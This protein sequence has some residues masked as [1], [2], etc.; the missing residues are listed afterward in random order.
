M[1][2]IS[3]KFNENTCEA[4]KFAIYSYVCKTTPETKTLPSNQDT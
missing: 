4:L 3:L 1:D 2:T